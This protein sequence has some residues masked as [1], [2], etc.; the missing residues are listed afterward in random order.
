MAVNAEILRP[1][2]GGQAIID[3]ALDMSIEGADRHLAAAVTRLDNAVKKPIRKAARIAKKA[4][5]IAS[6]PIQSHIDKINEFQVGAGAT[7]LVDEAEE[8]VEWFIDGA[9]KTARSLSADEK[10]RELTKGIERLKAELPAQKQ[11]SM[12]SMITKS[13]KAKLKVPGFTEDEIFNMT[14]AQ[15]L[16]YINGGTPR[17]T[18]AP[19]SP[20]QHDL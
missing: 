6:A 13:N 3:E 5:K 19:A 12:P 10:Y 4:A 7:N 20:P 16:A 15:A 9:I 11:A 14:P 17:V 18:D 2:P 1:S 8:T